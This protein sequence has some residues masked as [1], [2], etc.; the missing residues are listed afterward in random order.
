MTL[1][2]GGSDGLQC[3]C[4]RRLARNVWT[5]VARG[6]QPSIG[7]D[8]SEPRARC[9]VEH[10]QRRSVL[11]QA[12]A[13]IAEF[14]QRGFAIKQKQHCGVTNDTNLWRRIAE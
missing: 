1:W 4:R 7:T 8:P 13:A 9:F 10:Q 14:A 11:C 5:R 12:D 2:Q 6:V 3:G